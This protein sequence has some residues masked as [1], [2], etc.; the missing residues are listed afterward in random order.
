MNPLFSHRMGVG[1]WAWG[2]RL[3]WGYGRGYGEGALEGAFRASL[4]AGVRLFDTAEFYGFGLSERLLGR[5]MAR[6]GERPYLA[7]KFFPYPWRLSRK[8]LLEALRGS[9]ERLGVEAV[10]LY[11]LHWPWPPV[12]LRVWAEALAEAY[13]RGLAR[14]VGVCNATLAQVAEVKGVLDRHG[15]PLLALQV[16]YSLLKRDWEP[17]L[18][19]LRREGIALMAYSPLAMGW[20]TGKLD[21]KAPPPGYR[22]AKYRP[23]LG[24]VER[25]LPVLRAL[26]EAKGT[27]PAALALRYLMEKGDLPIP[28]AKNEAQARL[29]AEALRIALL[30]EEVALLEEAA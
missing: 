21:P 20:L 19:A 2:D 25:L 23:L 26:A 29:N 11:L 22:G 15:V 18:Q 12:P 8:H 10:D 16:E 14:G 24:K 4:E 28:G 17:H 30:P 7:T 6:S 3:F 1:T 27:S 5:F 9:L 13:E